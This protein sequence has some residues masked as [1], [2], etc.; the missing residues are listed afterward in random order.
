MDDDSHQHLG[1][2]EQF[3][4]LRI[5]ESFEKAQGEDFGRAWLKFRQSTAKSPPQFRSIV[6]RQVVGKVHG[7][8]CLAR[9]QDVES[10]IDRSTPEVTFLAVHSST[11]G[12]AKH[13]QEHD[14]QHVFGIRRVASDPVRGTEYQSVMRPKREF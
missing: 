14:L 11:V 7:A 13:P 4:N 1:D 8:V 12:L 5:C 6:M 2:A 9:S 3:G 10:G